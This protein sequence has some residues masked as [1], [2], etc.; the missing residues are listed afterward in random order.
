MEIIKDKAM[1]VRTATGKK[2]SRYSE[3]DQMEVGD[4]VI[5][6]TR[7]EANG[8]VVFLHHRQ[9]RAATRGLPDGTIGVWRTE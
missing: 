7:K 5:F 9:K 3:C 2:T 6:T 4:C 8:L 1:P